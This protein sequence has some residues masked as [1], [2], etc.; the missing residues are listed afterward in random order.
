MNFDTTKSLSLL[1]AE[2]VDQEK[3]LFPDKSNPEYRPSVAKV[4]LLELAR[5]SMT[6]MT[7]FHDLVEDLSSAASSLVL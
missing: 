2:V 4:S 6:S 1:P 7:S 3:I 5:G